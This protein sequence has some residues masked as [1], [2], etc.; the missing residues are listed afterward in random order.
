MYPRFK[1]LAAL[2]P[3]VFAT[4][5]QADTPLLVASLDPVMVTATRQ[6]MRSSELLSDVT[7]VESEELK[8][9][10]NSTLGEILSR[11]PGIEFYSQGS[12]GAT[13]SVFMRGTS[14]GHTLVLVDGMRVGSAS[15]GQM[16]SWS[17]I[18]ASQIERIEILR[19]PASSLYG[20]DAIGGVIQIFTR[21]GKGP[22]QVNAE[23]GI[24]SYNT[25][26]LTAGFS[27]SQADWRYSLNASS[28]R[29]DGFNS[30]KNPANSAYNKD[31]DGFENQSLSGSLGYTLA[32]GH[33]VGASFFYSDGESQYDSGT[34]KTAAAKD[35][36]NLLAVSNF[37]TYL[38]NAF[39][40]NWTS[41]LRAGHST[42][43]SKNTTNGVQNS[44]FR[45]D[46]EQYAWQNDIR[47]AVGN[48][49]L[50]IE[51]LDQSVTGTGNFRV[52]ERTVDSALVGWN[53][54]YLA[55]RLQ[56][57]L[58][59]DN[60]SQFGDK[61]TGSVA[62]GYRLNSNWRANVG[63][64][65]AF[66]APSF[67]DLYF[68]KSGKFIGNPDLLPESSRNREASVHYES[69]LHHVSLTWFLN[70]VENLIV[71]PSTGATITPANVSNARIEGATLAYEGQF[72]GF[73]LLAN[74]NYLD[75]RD[76]DTSRQLP[77]RASNYGT[78]S[79]GQQIGAWEWRVEQFASDRRFSDDKNLLK[80]HGYSLTNLYGAYNFGQ[81]W[82]V[83]ARINNLFDRNYE[84]VA[85]F[86]TP[87]T[88]AFVGVRYSP[89]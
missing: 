57:N 44:L 55:H 20:S 80:L 63:Y 86:A 30:I 59:Y 38:K 71:W 49:L 8:Q 43:D 23:A 16:S 14:S 37:S 79:I 65:T 52:T 33:E 69:G 82:S 39:T 35:Y 50:G 32:K 17:R 18:P 84:V 41:T 48:F 85:D 26:T 75:P 73:D 64:G 60:N 56:A 87:G 77:R 34:T 89:K 11:Q 7:V 10:G 47:T 28:Y 27:G 42:D 81:N 40:S 62:Y 1:P 31:R 78:V 66:K 68:P 12:N 46:Q 21:T 53:G 19:G 13:G 51:R 3:L 88:N 2:L 74:Y 29:T 24:G 58:R 61:A 67:N 22:F 45:T 4:P 5:S 83:F 54:S 25:S 15:L 36:R 70:S 72:A 6:E 9:A 76:T